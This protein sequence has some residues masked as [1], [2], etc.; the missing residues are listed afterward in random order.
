MNKLILY[1]LVLV[2]FTSCKNRS[3]EKSTVN[4]ETGSV[5]IVPLKT[6]EGYQINQFSGDSIGIQVNPAGV[7]IESGHAIVLKGTALTSAQQN[8]VKKEA[9]PELQPLYSNVHPIPSQLN[10]VEY[11]SSA[12]SS[13]ISANNKQIPLINSTGDTVITGVWLPVTG[14]KKECSLSPLVEFDSPGKKDAASLD[15]EFL[16][17]EQGLSS[18]Y[19]LAI[20]KDQH[21]NLWLGTL[22]GGVVR[23]NGHSSFRINMENGLESNKIWAIKID[24]QGN[25]WIGTDGNGV[26]KYDGDSLSCFNESHGL[27]NNKILSLLED[28]KG[29][30]WFGTNDGGASCYNGS[31]LITYAKNE[32]LS[33]IIVSMFEDKNGFIWFSS[34]A[35]GVFKFDGNS[36]TQITTE[37]GLAH[38]SVMPIM[39][40]RS[41]NIWFGTWGGG[42]SV[43]N[44]EKFTQYTTRDGLIDN[45]INALSE[46]P[47]GTVWIGTWEGLSK[48]DGISFT[49]FST[50]DGLTN[51]DIRTILT[52]SFNNV[53]M[54]SWGGGLMNYHTNG[55]SNLGSSNGLSHT[56]V[57]SIVEDGQNNLWFGTWNG[58]SKLESTQILNFKQGS[59]ISGSF[60]TALSID[61][62]GNVW[63][64]AENGVL[65]RFDGR[66]FESFEDLAMPNNYINK[67]MIDRKQNIWLATERSGLIKYDSKLFTKYDPHTGFNDYSVSDILEDTNGNIWAATKNTGLLKIVNDSVTFYT[68][69]EGLNSN[70]L[71]CLFEDVEGK[72]LIGTEDAGLCV[73]DGTT[74]AYYTASEG[75]SSNTI[76]S[77]TEDSEK[78]FWIGTNNGLNILVGLNSSGNDI[79][80]EKTNAEPDFYVANLGT[81]DGLRALDFNDKSMY[82]DSRQR[83]WMGTGKSLSVIDLRQFKINSTTQ[84][85]YVSQLTVNDK[86]IDFKQKGTESKKWKYDSVL[87]FSNVPL[88]PIIP[89]SGN[90]LSFHFSSNNFS[91]SKKTLYSYR[92]A[93][94]EDFWSDPGSK[95]Y[96]DYRNLPPGQKTLQI[97]V[98]NPFGDN[99]EITS[100][101]FRILPPWYKSTLANISFAVLLVFAVIMVIG[102]RTYTLT[103]RKNELL[104][105]VAELRAAKQ[106]AE[107]SDRLKTAFL[108][109]LSHEIRTPLNGI[110]GFSNL[111]REKDLSGDTR[112]KYIDL[113]N[114]SG[115][116]LLNTMNN[117]VEIS[118]VETGQI[119]LN[120]T[121]FDL[122]GEMRSI[123]KTF[124]DEIH[125]KGLTYDYDDFLADTKLEVFTDQEKLHGIFD[126]LIKNAIKYTNSGGI[127]V[128]LKA[129]DSDN[130]KIELYVQDSG[131]GIAAD[132]LQAVFEPFVQADIE[133]KHAMQGA[134]VGLS[135]AKAYVIL[136]GGSIQVKSKK[137]LGSTVSF[138]IKYKN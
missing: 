58:I 40:D 32:G 68:V 62:S 77:V 138:D 39:E 135:I 89:Y 15:I 24:S 93:E 76:R 103:K 50:D 126:Q 115:N 124:T 95:T 116:R 47:D 101:T 125:K 6:A 25:I 5:R 3:S 41:G 107:E 111:L 90:H 79:L 131:I 109:N 104:K 91:S 99:S 61:S 127:K 134:G 22:D 56:H 48:F 113:I 27:G 29:N 45:N 70:K 136:L 42:I 28:S 53:W 114:R 67:I 133:D 34:Y 108:L 137:G 65:N 64:G 30:I 105:L 11:D 46:A 20:D 121:S 43:F 51:N 83:L 8:K 17:M 44:G 18:S 2:L 120:C 132:R 1:L 75:L 80:N 10:T 23:Y 119:T 33:N 82:F 88:N 13:F 72:L 12:T 81:E 26:Y 98:V 129:I 36:F 73:F 16:D 49:N 66:Y 96:A 86:F 71:S 59:G 4:P 37:N 57:N 110:L 84:K 118:R 123:C 31:S 69:K 74:F 21:G 106:K 35:D 87:A 55:F 60:G 112:G 92:I 63:I 97:K 7:K 9:K 38:N 52:D 54:G 19:V 78:R 102:I 130:Q 100:Y 94:L 117:L 14:L 85:A 128:G 122:F